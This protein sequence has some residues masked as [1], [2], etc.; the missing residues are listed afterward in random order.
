VR[1]SPAVGDRGQDGRGADD[2]LT[3]DETGHRCGSDDDVRCVWTI[4][5]IVVGR[6]VPSYIVCMATNID[7]FTKLSDGDLLVQVVQLAQCERTATARLIASLAEFDQRRIYL[8]EGFPSLFVFC[9]QRLRLSE[10][11]AYHR[12][13]AARAARRFPAILEF[14]EQGAL[15]LTAVCLLRPHL[16]E[17]NHRE[18]LEAARHLGKSAVEELVARLHARPDVRTSVRKL[19]EPRG[20][21]GQESLIGAALASVHSD[22]VPEVLATDAAEQ[23]PRQGVH[24]IPPSRPAVVRPLAPARYQVQMTVSA[25]TLAKLRHAQN[26]LR[27]AVPNGDPA[28]IFDRALTLLVEQ[29]ERTKCAAKKEPAKTSERA[30]GVPEMLA[31]ASSRNPATRGTGKPSRKP[32]SRSS[33]VSSTEP[34]TEK[35]QSAPSRRIPAAVKREVWKRDGGQCAFVG[36]S[37]RCAERGG[38]E[39]HHRVPF[40]AGGESTV[41]NVAVMCRRHNAYEADQFFGAGIAA[42]GDGSLVGPDRVGGR[43]RHG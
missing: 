13:E 29:L 21:V 32:C 17:E 20:Q 24:Q 35:K 7:A 10:H 11:A 37:G 5:G 18:V 26:L 8:P 23:E 25:E 33:T 12:I 30:P 34:G 15:T 41:A 6:K 31:R 27:H 16:T 28:V 4:R 22:A 42:H 36:T 14:L 1:R 3:R 38:L 43:D 9:T 39:F 40:A 19:P 2:D